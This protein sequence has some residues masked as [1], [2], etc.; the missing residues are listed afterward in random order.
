V[1]AGDLAGARLTATLTGN[2]EVKYYLDMIAELR[3]ER[4]ADK[5]QLTTIA[6]QLGV[7]QA[8][9]DR[10]DALG[11]K[12][13]A[14]GT[15]LPEDL[16]DEPM[17]GKGGKGGKDGQGGPLN[18]APKTLMTLVELQKKAA[19]LESEADLAEVALETSLAMAIRK[20]LG[21]IQG[22]GIPYLWPL[23]TISYRLSSPFGWREDPVHGK[24]A[25][26][27]GMDLADAQGNPVVAAADGV[28][29]FVGWRAGYGN[30]VV[31]EHEQ[32]FSTRY[33]HLQK[34]VAK[35][36]QRVNAGDLIALLGNTGRSTGAHLHFEVR[37][38]DQ[39]LNPFPFIRESR[40]DVFQQARNGRGK[41][42]LAQYRQGLQKGTARR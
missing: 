11:N 26:H 3:A 40:A 21:P 41:E 14:E 29:S 28:V 36:G 10:F 13:K 33:G 25:W 19:G 4:D 15:L 34:G 37:K 6:K 42:L 39:A 2:T 18:R 9:I 5:Q 27:A 32:G 38:N 8:R 24:R 35:V 31:I 30:L 1:L 22:G 16:G 7:L 23:M 12:L 20:A 17:E